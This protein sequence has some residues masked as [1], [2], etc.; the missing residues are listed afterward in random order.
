MSANLPLINKVV[1]SALVLMFLDV[2][3]PMQDLLLCLE[4]QSEAS[5]DFLIDDSF[6][7]VQFLLKSSMF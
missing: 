2:V 3:Y 4:C 5:L 7:G 1:S 6:V